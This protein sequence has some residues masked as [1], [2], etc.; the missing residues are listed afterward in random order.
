VLRYSVEMTTTTFRYHSAAV[1]IE[2]LQSSRHGVLQIV[3]TGPLTQ[4]ALD[5]FRPRVLEAIK[6]APVSVLRFDT[7][8]ELLSELPRPVPQA[9]ANG[10]RAQAVVVS[11]ARYRAW[12]EH[13]LG[14]CQMGVWRTIWS[15]DQV[16]RAH[17]WADGVARRQPPQRHHHDEEPMMSGPAPLS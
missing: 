1:R 7:A 6:G 5:Y 2:P 13:A 4:A 10:A 14:L 16:S 11:D 15:A 9:Y 12:M 3:A 8:V 17:H